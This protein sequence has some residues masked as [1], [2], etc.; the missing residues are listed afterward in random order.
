MD[1]SPGPT[2]SRLRRRLLVVLAL[3]AGAVGLSLLVSSIAAV[4]LGGTVMVVRTG[5]MSPRLPA[6]SVVL[7]RPVASGSLVRGEVVGVR[8]PDGRVVVH[9]VRSVTAAPGAP[10]LRSVVLRG[11]ANDVNDPPVLTDTALRPLLVVPYSWPGRMVGV[12]Q[13]RWAQFWLGVLT[14]S[15]AT[16]EW[17][18]SGRRRDATVAEAPGPPAAGP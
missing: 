13:A 11:D 5:S 7:A 10:L 16:A 17:V 9:R 8:H 3:A 12:L 4:A 2:G 1:A 6:G 15:L 18:R 14:G